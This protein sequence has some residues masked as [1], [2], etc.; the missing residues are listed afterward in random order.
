M[1]TL[2][3]AGIGHLIATDKYPW[4][5]P[6]H[7]PLAFAIFALTIWLTVRAP[8]LRPASRRGR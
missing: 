5:V 2:L 4:L 3:E 8:A 7:V 6:V 1:P